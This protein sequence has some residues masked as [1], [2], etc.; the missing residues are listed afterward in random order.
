MSIFDRSSSIGFI[1]AG[2]VGSCLAISL[3]RLGYSVVAV[4]SRTPSSARSLAS[5]IA[6]CQAYESA[7][8]T[9]EASD[10]VFI[11]TPD[12]TIEEVAGS[13]QWR[14]GQGVVHCSGAYSTEVLSPAS[15]QGA[16]VGAFHPF[17]T[18]P[19]LEQAL[20]NLP[21]SAFA[22]EGDP[23]L[24]AFLTE[25]AL[26]LHGDPLVLQPGDKELYHIS[27]VSV[28]AFVLGLVNQAT[29]LWQKLGKEREEAVRAM[30]PILKGTVDSLA[31][32]GIPGALTGPYE[33][34]DVAT[35]RKHLAALERRAP[36]FLH[37][38]SLL[39]LTQLPLGIEKGRLEPARASEIR[40]IINSYIQGEAKAAP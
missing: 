23:P 11:T 1:G 38:Y 37:L 34:G 14:K 5:R 28:C 15:A 6:G 26:G 29:G 16:V 3:D 33:R 4:S 9:S 25:V 7:Q 40:E 2:I 27:A 30:L 32:Q 8:R 17:Q 20:Q 22:I 19:S 39:A 12:D 24:E 10:V 18:F 31:S 36:E 13:V 21:G 35:I